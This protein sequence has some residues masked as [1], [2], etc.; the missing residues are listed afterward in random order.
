MT[1]RPS[2][3]NSSD[4][5]APHWNL[6]LTLQVLTYENVNTGNFEQAADVRSKYAG[7]RWFLEKYRRHKQEPTAE[8]F[9]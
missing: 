7:R 3:F 4:P 6:V 1:V 9:E 2:L 8:N 5:V